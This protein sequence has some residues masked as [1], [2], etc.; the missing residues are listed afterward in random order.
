MRRFLREMVRAIAQLSLPIKIAI[1]AAIVVEFIVITQWEHLW[2]GSPS[3]AALPAPAQPPQP[4]LPSEPSNVDKSLSD[5][6]A[7]AFLIRRMAPISITDPKIERDGRINE[8]GRYLSL[9]GVKPF[10][11][12]TVCTRSSGER[13]ACGLHAYATLRNELAHKTIVCEPKKIVDE[14]LSVLCRLDNQDVA[15][16]LVRQGLA[17][18][19]DAGVSNELLGAQAEA[20]KKKIGIWDR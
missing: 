4:K 19:T 11:A 16:I 15:A 18:V 3:H 14:G 17:E 20:R 12:K 13:W 9:Y 1:G 10:D 5:Q 6:Q 7:Q 8:G 2:S